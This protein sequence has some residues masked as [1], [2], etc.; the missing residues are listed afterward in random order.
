MLHARGHV[1][2]APLAM[3]GGANV[4]TSR[5]WERGTGGWDSL[6]M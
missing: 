6:G 5:A 3:E 4:R 1:S 2:T